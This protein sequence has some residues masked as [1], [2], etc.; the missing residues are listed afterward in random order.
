MSDFYKK[1]LD[2]NKVANIAEK[3]K[4]IDNNVS[5]KYHYYCETNTR[6]LIISNF[7]TAFRLKSNPILFPKI[8]CPSSMIRAPGKESN[9]P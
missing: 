2:K 8:T 5:E 4:N 7:F 3:L 9:L 1:I 6:H